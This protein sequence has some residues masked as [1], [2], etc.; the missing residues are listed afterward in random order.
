MLQDLT[1][2]VVMIDDDPDF[3]LDYM[4]EIKEL[5][6]KSGYLLEHQRYEKLEQLDDSL[7]DDVDLFLVD[8][9]FGDEDKGPEFIAKIREKYSTD[10][11]FYSSHK[12]AIEES[13]SKG[14]YEGV[15]FAVRDDN[16][17]E[18]ENKI[19][20]LIEKMIKHSN[21]PLASRGIVLGS[22]AEIDNLIKK[23]ISELLNKMD[24][25]QVDELMDEC[26][27]HYHSSFNNRCNKYKEFFGT[28]FHNGK[29]KRGDVIENYEKYNILELIDNISITDSNKNLHV[30]LKSYKT[31]YKKKDDTYKA[32]ENFKNLLADRNTLAHV[33]E[34]RN[35]KG[36]YQFKRAQKG[37]NLVLTE[38]K[39]RELRKTIIRYYKIINSISV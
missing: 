30:L 26:T 36:E 14:E 9:K 39:S 32:I 7:L 13:R 33:C 38:R 6:D 21:T 28:E 12:D 5:L 10:I 20:Q 35:E 31:L 23:K 1:Y 34:T 4:E 27:K 25:D 11:L 22:V 18:I 19:E 3:Y 24:S 2:R 17:K 15:F 8:L 37:G 29:R 16:T